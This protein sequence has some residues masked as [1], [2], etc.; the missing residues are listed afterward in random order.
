MPPPTWTAAPRVLLPN[1]RTATGDASSAVLG[2]RLFAHL[3]R[4]RAG[5]YGR[6]SPGSAWRGD[7]PP[8][9]ASPQALSGRALVST[10]GT[11]RPCQQRSCPPSVRVLSDQ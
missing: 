5:G 2:V 7:R 8:G 11:R 4:R 1:Q 6:V 9:A 10:V 3:V